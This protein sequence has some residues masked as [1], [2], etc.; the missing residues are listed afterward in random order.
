MSSKYF[1]DECNEEMKYEN[2][3]PYLPINEI[4]YPYDKMGKIKITWPFSSD[5]CVK[6]KSKLLIEIAAIVYPN[7]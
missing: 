4:I 3:E 5:I 1:C 2:Q 6:C 7:K